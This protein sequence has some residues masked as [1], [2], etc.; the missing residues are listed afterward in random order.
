MPFLSDTYCRT[1]VAAAMLLFGL[2]TQDTDAVLVSYQCTS[3]LQDE[4]GCM[5]C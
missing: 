5:I 4:T 2:D 1:T 3:M